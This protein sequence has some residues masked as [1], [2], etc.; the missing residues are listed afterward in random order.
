MTPDST[1]ASATQSLSALPTFSRFLEV[2]AGRSSWTPEDREAKQRSPWWLVREA[3]AYAIL[4]TLHDAPSHETQLRSRLAS[5]V[6]CILELKTA[7]VRS[8]AGEFVKALLPK[9]MQAAF[10]QIRSELI[11]IHDS[12]AHLANVET[13]PDENAGRTEFEKHLRSALSKL[14][15]RDRRLIEMSFLNEN[16]STDEQIAAAI[17]MEVDEM[18][19]ARD[20]ILDQIDL[21]TD[22]NHN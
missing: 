5:A 2:A 4:A 12:T 14:S 22:T 17:G 9:H 3:E 8:V 11:R 7:Q 19:L 1:P 15:E 6:S 20:T 10:Y 13:P 16:S 21:D 18:R